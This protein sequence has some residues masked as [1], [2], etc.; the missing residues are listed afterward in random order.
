MNH[1]SPFRLLLIIELKIAI[2][3]FASVRRSDS[4]VALIVPLSASNSIQ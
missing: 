4:F 2:N 3:S 1:E